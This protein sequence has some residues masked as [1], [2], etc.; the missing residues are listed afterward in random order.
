MALRHPFISFTPSVQ[1]KALIFLS[2]STIVVMIALIVLD[3]PLQTESAPH[4][5]VSFEFAG[6]LSLAQEMLESWGSTG[7]LYAALSLGL[8]YLYL[9][10]YSACIA[11]GCALVASNLATH[12]TLSGIGIVLSW[13]QFGAGGLDVLENIALIRILLGSELAFWPALSWWCALPKFVIVL[14]GLG[15]IVIGTILLTKKKLNW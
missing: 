3:S 5:I 1:K 13:A 6:T 15:Y 10:L 11:L 9:V 7:Q 8:D 14:A 2:L 4:G 12:K